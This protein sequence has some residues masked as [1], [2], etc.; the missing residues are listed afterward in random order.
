MKNIKKLLT[1][2][3]AMCT[4]NGEKFLGEQLASIKNQKYPIFELIVFDD[5]SSDSTLEILKEFKDRSIF[6]VHIYSNKVN[7]GLI[8]NFEY[9]TSCCSGDLIAFSDQ[10]DIW[11][12]HKINVIVDKFLSNPDCGYVF[13][14]AELI[15]A[16]G[17]CLNMNL[18]KSIQFNDYRQKIFQSK[19]QFQMMLSGGS[20]I[21][22]MSLVIRS[23][24]N[25]DILPIQSESLSCTHDTWISLYLSAIGKYGIPVPEPLVKY[26]QHESQMF[27]G[28]KKLNLIKK[29]QLVFSEPS[30][31]DHNKIIAL[32]RM[33][34]CLEKNSY[35]SNEVNNARN[36]LIQ[37]CLHLRF[38][39]NSATKSRFARMLIIVPE[40]LSGRY[41]I[42]SS[43]IFS[44]LKDLAR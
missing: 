29:I 6:P 36:L 17:K 34:S 41:G 39:Y 21:Y 31:I 42:Y 35:L 30:E 24:Y 26:R 2:S 10:D 37:L 4:F 1:V 44:I 23:E 20:F 43:S 28:G 7:I 25:S 18:W 16:N 40:I 38:R 14:D 19:R 9:A 13:S 3:V 32:E 8:K 33:A 12:Q 15:D 5:A 11:M 27:G 22:G